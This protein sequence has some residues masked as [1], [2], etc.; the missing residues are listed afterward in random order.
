MELTV[1]CGRCRGNVFCAWGF[2]RW[3]CQQESCNEAHEI[4]INEP[5]A[6][7]FRITFSPQNVY[8]GHWGLEPA[9]A[10]RLQGAFPRHPSFSRHFHVTI[11]VAFSS[12]RRDTR[13]SACPRVAELS[14]YDG[15]CAAPPAVGRW[16]LT[17]ATVE[18][19][20]SGRV[21]RTR[22]LIASYRGSGLP[23]IARHR[24]ARAGYE[25]ER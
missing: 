6:M 13:S 20:G 5:T 24:D 4:P 17:W 12:C 22:P 19:T 2:F 11:M 16:R 25:A 8:A 9:P 21:R 10:G 15:L 14:S 7:S 3:C 23:S 18:A 1:A